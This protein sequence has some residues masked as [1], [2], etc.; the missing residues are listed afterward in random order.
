VTTLTTRVGASRFGDN[1]YFGHAALG[2][3]LGPETATGLVAMA[4]TG[5]RPDALQ[6]TMLDELAV[7]MTSADPRIWPLKLT[8]I[9]ASYGGTLAGFAAGHLAMEGETIGPWIIGHA[10]AQLERLR[11]D[12]GGS[13]SD[14]GGLDAIVQRHVDAT[15]RVV[16][17]GVPLRTSDERMDALTA[18]VAFHARD[19]L[20]Y[21][22]LQLAL[23]KAVRRTHGLAPNV[24]IGMAAMLLDLGYTPTEASGLTTFLNQNVFVA[25]AVEGARQAAEDLRKLPDECVQYAGHPARESPRALA[26][27]TSSK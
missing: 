22:R 12:V 25:N 24:G 14:V 1:R 21:W 11:G 4:V 18:R 19:A 2:E 20:P 5:R 26:A 23:S 27:Q 16:G 13:L 15:K 8:R 3:L 17:Y 6:R 10:A 7:I 9:V